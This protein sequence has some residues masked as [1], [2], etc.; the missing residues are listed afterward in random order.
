MRVGQVIRPLFVFLCSFLI[1]TGVASAQN[2]ETGLPDHLH[3]DSG[4]ERA[5]DPLC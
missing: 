1:A 5:G 3:N 4:T 2:S